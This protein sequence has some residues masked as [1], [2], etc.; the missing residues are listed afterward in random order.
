MNPAFEHLQRLTFPYS[1]IGQGPITQGGLF[2]IHC[3]ALK[4]E[5]VVATSVERAYDTSGAGTNDDV[6]L[7]RLG[8]ERLDHTYVRK[9][10]S[11]ATT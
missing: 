4:L 5:A 9:P 7:Y 8:F 6:E 1:A 10:L 11:G 3:Y 2:H